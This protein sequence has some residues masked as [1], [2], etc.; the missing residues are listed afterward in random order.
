LPLILKDQA[1][2]GLS[3][4]ADKA[5]GVA[6]VMSVLEGLS[7][8]NT[9]RPDVIFQRISTTQYLLRLG[10]TP[11][12][13]ADYLIRFESVRVWYTTEGMVH[14]PITVA[15]ALGLSQ[16]HALPLKQPPQHRQETPGGP[17]YFIHLLKKKGRNFEGHFVVGDGKKSFMNPAG[18]AIVSASD[19]VLNGYYDT[20]LTVVVDSGRP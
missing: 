9:D 15:L 20:H 2:L 14:T 16:C 12:N 10:S 5:C 7:V 6:C 13:I 11:A 17:P 18:G 19:L 4:G 3:K 8:T 1:T